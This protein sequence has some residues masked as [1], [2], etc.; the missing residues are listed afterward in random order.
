[1][2]KYNPKNWFKLIFAL[3]KSDTLRMLWKEILYIG[4]FSALLSF[5]MIEYF[6]GIEVLES[7][8]S[9]Y[10]IVGFVIS[11]LLVF[12]TNTAYDRWWEGR[13]KWGS[14]VNDTRNLAIKIASMIDDKEHRTFFKSAIPNFVFATKEHLRNGVDFSELEL[15]EH[16][17]SELSKKEHVP[18]AISQMM[19]SRVHQLTKDEKI[20]QEE[21]L[22]L[23]KNMNALLDS[24]GACER[25]KNTPIPFSYSLFL[26]KF[27]FIYVTTIP[28]AFIPVFGYYSIIIAMFLFYVLVSMEILAEE[29]EDPFGNDDNDL[30]TH[31]LCVKIKANVI[32]ILSK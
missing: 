30:P 16:E 22:A 17:L 1:M 29:I 5:T 15:S 9:V 20:S 14:L 21:F 10:S 12:R 3:H 2:I 25:I 4:V 13:K 26:K 18:N 7:L 31:N 19:Y 6:D 24:L 27:I 28:L 11:L 8:L 23:D 32:E